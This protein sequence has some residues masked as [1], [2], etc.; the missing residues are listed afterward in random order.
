MGRS[1]K[2]I[3]LGELSPLPSLSLAQPCFMSCPFIFFDQHLS[4]VNSMVITLIILLLF[5]SLAI[6]LLLQNSPPKTHD[7]FSLL[8]SVGGELKMNKTW[9]DQKSAGVPLM[10]QYP[11]IAACFQHQLLLQLSFDFTKCGRVQ[12]HGRGGGWWWGHIFQKSETHFE[13]IHVGK[14]HFGKK[15]FWKIHFRKFTLKKYT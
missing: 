6:F 9:N 12:G 7:E 4:L 3:N 13:K 15:H 8:T 1:K 2:R 14:I 10:A 5:T 11:R